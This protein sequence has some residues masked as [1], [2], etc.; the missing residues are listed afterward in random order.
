MGR[1]ASPERISIHRHCDSAEI[2]RSAD[3]DQVASVGSGTSI[4]LDCSNI[5]GHYSQELNP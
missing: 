5:K 2:A 3:C 1:V 4:G